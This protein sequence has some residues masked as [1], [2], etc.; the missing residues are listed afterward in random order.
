MTMTVISIAALV[1]VAAG[2]LCVYML[3]KLINPRVSSE[4]LHSWVDINAQSSRPLE[5]LLDPS[6]FEYLR[7]RGLGKQRIEQ[8]QAQRRKL[9]RMYLRRL[10]CDFNTACCAISEMLVNSTVD[11]PGSRP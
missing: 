9:F 8:L 5:R 3:R 7:R 2:I 4:D 1:A 11:R 10:T 6:E